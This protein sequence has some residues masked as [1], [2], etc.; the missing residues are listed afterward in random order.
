MKGAEP[1]IVML[2]RNGKLAAIIPLVLRRHLGAKVAGM[3]GGKHFNYQAP[4]WRPEL[5]RRRG[6]R[7]HAPRRC[8]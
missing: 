4:A 2:R 7:C 8:A 1:R 3:I 6:P 5:F